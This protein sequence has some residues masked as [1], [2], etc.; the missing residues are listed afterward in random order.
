MHSVFRILAALL[1]CT[2]AASAFA[3]GGK[4]STVDVSEDYSALAAYEKGFARG[5][6]RDPNGVR[7]FDM[8]LIQDDAP[9]SGQSEKGSYIQSIHGALMARKDLF[10]EDPRTN[11]AY[12]VFIFAGTG[13]GKLTVTV[14]GSKTS[15]DPATSTNTEMYRL[16]AVDPATLKKG[17][18]SIVLSY[19]EGNERDQYRILFS[20]KDEFAHGGGDPAKAGLNSYV[21]ADG[22]KTWK[23]GAFGETG[24]EE[25]EL[26]VRLSLDRHVPKGWLASPVID[27]WRGPQDGFIVPLSLINRVKITASGDVPPGATITWQVRHGAGPDPLAVYWSKYQTVGEGASASAD[28]GDP[29]GRYFQW[30]AVLAAADPRTTPV[31]KSV[32]LERRLTRLDHLPDN[33]YITAI[34]NPEILY[35]SL[36]GAYE[37][38]DDPGLKTLREREKL[39]TVVAG[40]RTEF[41][42]MVKLMDY[43]AKRWV[44]VSPVP[45]YP[46]WNALEI[47]D[48]ID[49]EGGGGM[50][51]HFAI[52]MIQALQSYGIP[53]RLQN[54]VGH[55]VVEA[56]SNDFGKWVFF[57]PMQGSNVYNYR[58][59]DG[60]PVGFREL[61]EVYLDLFYPDRPINWH[62]DP[63]VYR[64]A[65]K[66]SPIAAGTLD[67]NWPR[68][69]GSDSLFCGLA[70]A[71]FLRM[72]PRD[73]WLKNGGP[74]PL[75]HGLTEYG[76]PDYINWYDDRTPR[77]RHQA[78]FTD[79]AAD[80]WPTLNRVKMDAVTGPEN[81]RVFL[82]FTTFTPNF[83]TYLVEV[84]EVG[85]T[86][87]SEFFPWV[88]HSGKNTLRVRVKNRLGSLGLPSAVTINLA[89]RPNLRERPG[90]NR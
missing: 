55:E 53:A 21:S 27:L 87:S 54:C 75:G 62:T 80:Y 25:G 72:M 89:D 28:L 43:A 7:L 58:K 64:A 66:D 50:C 71:A 59:K 9:G 40:C 12:V 73:D 14:N 48:R 56:W 82:R 47:L 32:R 83:D 19:P 78:I 77:Q 37:P 20:R 49:R 31:V 11:S 88:L 57:D 34:E 86:P 17:L 45:Q 22:G 51:I 79:R 68:S 24:K 26:A 61:H 52:L 1:L 6:M 35:S 63:M 81:D 90:G 15:Y 3:A 65:P 46:S 70:N 23:R 69:S 74:E 16:V 41:E 5:V 42:K 8:E 30:R 10:I 85:W 29:G 4:Q 39:D 76:W 2:G 44:W 84:D 13:K 18:N 36:Y 67:K 33:I 38:W 60:E